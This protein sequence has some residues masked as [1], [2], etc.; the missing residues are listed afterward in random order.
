MNERCHDWL[1]KAGPVTVPAE[2]IV[3]IAKEASVRFL[4]KLNTNQF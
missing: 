2:I 1:L 3:E 4:W